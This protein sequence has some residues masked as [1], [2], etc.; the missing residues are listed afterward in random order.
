MSVLE[1]KWGDKKY[2][3]GLAY[4][5]TTIGRGDE[6]LIQL[7]DKKVSRRHC[8]ILKT[9]KGYQIVDNKSGNGTFVNG[10]RLDGEYYLKDSDVIRLTTT[11]GAV[12]MMFSS[13]EFKAVA[14]AVAAAQP[15][16]AASPPPALTDISI[17]DPQGHPVGG[18]PADDEMVGAT[19]AV[20]DVEMIKEINKEIDEVTPEQIV[21]P[22]PEPLPMPAPITGGPV[23]PK[24][25]PA[26]TATT[27]PPKPEPK[28][29][30][31]AVARP[32]EHPFGRAVKTAPKPAVPPPPTTKT[33]PAAKPNRFSK[34]SK[35][36]GKTGSI[37]PLGRTGKSKQPV[38]AGGQPAETGK[39]DKKSTPAMSSKTKN[40]ML[41]GGI[42]AVVLMS[43][44]LLMS[45]EASAKRQIEINK[46][47][48]EL[49][50]QAKGL[51]ESKKY[52]DAIKK[53]NEF[54]DDK[55]FTDAKSRDGVQK[56][57]ELLE[58]QIKKEKAADIKLAPLVQKTNSA[59]IK[60]Y[61]EILG[62]LKSFVEEYNG[63]EAM[64]K[65]QAEYQRLQRIAASHKESDAAESF[66]KTRSEA[67]KLVKKKKYDDA[68]AKWGEFSTL[69]PNLDDILRNKVNNEIQRIK[70]IMEQKK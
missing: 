28:K 24:P 69:Y 11:T 19:T 17:S 61:P 54:L 48:T 26:A 53:L 7:K 29:P 64:V 21:A 25:A 27:A 5:V 13:E 36:L 39:P 3:I 58:D 32:D 46:K 42:A 45:S 16:P 49:L 12:E 41:I 37:K 60:E 66:G 6:N 4:D 2:S 68:L 43:V 47:E 9:P 20:I 40:L 70:N 51:A 35:T 65:A 57:V 63:T 10:L 31:T 55:D 62:E 8:K 52:Y 44:A 15:Q 18:S 56:Q 14:E 67:D 59:E 34:L 33:V 50:K 23:A 30:T 22:V 1:V 38:D